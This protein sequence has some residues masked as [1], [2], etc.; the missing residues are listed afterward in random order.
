MT[1]RETI[2]NRSLQKEQMTNNYAKA[3]TFTAKIA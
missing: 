1:H 3:G 2:D